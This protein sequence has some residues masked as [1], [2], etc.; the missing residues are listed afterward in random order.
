MHIILPQ[1]EEKKNPDRSSWNR[2]MHDC[3]RVA[4]EVTHITKLNKI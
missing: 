4:A 2:R 1:F 3:R